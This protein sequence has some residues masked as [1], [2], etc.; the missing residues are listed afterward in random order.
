MKSQQEMV[1]EFVRGVGHPVPDKPTLLTKEKR[2]LCASLILEEIVETLTGLGFHID[3]DRQTCQLVLIPLDDDD[4]EVGEGLAFKDEHAQLIEIID[5][6]ADSEVVL[7]FAATL[8][9]ITIRP[10]FDEVCRS[11]MT[12]L[13]GE[14]KYNAE[15]KLLKPP[16]YSPADLQSV[17]DRIY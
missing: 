16:T 10:F 17:F 11:N 4:P 15:G 14:R 5:G 12:K 2:R 3:V 13:D 7:K 6:L 8:M 1:E 9:G